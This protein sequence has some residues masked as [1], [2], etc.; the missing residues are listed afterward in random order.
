MSDR[1]ILPAELRD[2]G[3]VMSIAVSVADLRAEPNGKRDRQMI[4]GEDF[5]VVEVRDDWAYGCSEKD[6]YA[7]YLR[8]TDLEVRRE[9]THFVSARSSH[10]YPESD[11]KSEALA[12]LSFGARLD[13]VSKGERFAELAGGGF[14]PGSHITP[15]DH[16]FDDPI[17]V[18]ER[19]MGVPYLWGGNSI[20]GLDC[21]GLVQVALL[22]CGVDCPGDADMQQAS[23]GVAIGD[24][25]K[26]QRGDLFFWKGHVG[27]VRDENTLLHANAYHMAVVDEPLD[28]AIERIMAQGDGPVT[29]RRRFR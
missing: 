16:L 5:R 29:G 12:A 17:E 8:L 10:I 21:S 28:Q 1:R 14:V 18:A 23:V 4:Y 25:I 2:S 3:E 9:Q 22:T 20:W 11:F 26:P 6:G 27:L 13:I 7:G 15:I 19:F 24:N